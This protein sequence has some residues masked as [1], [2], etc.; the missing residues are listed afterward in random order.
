MEG[1]VIVTSLSVSGDREYAA[2]LWME[3]R[4]PLTWTPTG[5]SGLGPQ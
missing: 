1:V 4:I 5:P 3:L 2:R